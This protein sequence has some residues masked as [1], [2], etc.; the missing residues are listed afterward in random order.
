MSED[1]D[2]SDFHRGYEDFWEYLNPQSDNMEYMEGWH[3]AEELFNE[4][5]K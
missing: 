4:R 5:N 2:F 3:S 1:Y